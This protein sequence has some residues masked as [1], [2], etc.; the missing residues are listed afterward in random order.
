MWVVGAGILGGMVELSRGLDKLTRQPYIVEKGYH[1]ESSERSELLWGSPLCNGI[2]Q[3]R[4]W[5]DGHYW[6]VLFL[7]AGTGF[8]LARQPE[9]W[10]RSAPVLYAVNH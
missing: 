8:V 2:Q 1:H 10:V 3:W 6:N 7:L 9:P 4:S 5:L